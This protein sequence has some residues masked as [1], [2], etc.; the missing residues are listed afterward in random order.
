MMH[1]MVETGDLHA[2]LIGQPHQPVMNGLDFISGFGLAPSSSY[3][4]I[5]DCVRAHKVPMSAN[6]GVR[7]LT[8]LDAP[9]WPGFPL[10]K[11]GLLL[12]CHGL[13][14]SVQPCTSS[15]PICSLSAGVPLPSLMARPLPFGSPEPTQDTWCNL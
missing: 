2:R 14:S 7:A 1:L 8:V 9:F 3:G 13:G 5:H 6:C 12:C 11:H 15:S 10:D 4:I